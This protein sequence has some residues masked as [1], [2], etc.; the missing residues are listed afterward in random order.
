M[1]EIL[2]GIFFIQKV[3]Q[4]PLNILSVELP[5]VIEPMSVEYHVA[6]SNVY[7]CSTPYGY[8]KRR[9]WNRICII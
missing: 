2:G 6:E 1:V 7:Q 3:E 9:S 8:R 4:L 5:V